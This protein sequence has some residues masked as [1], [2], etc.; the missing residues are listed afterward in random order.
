MCN[1]GRAPTVPMVLVLWCPVGFGACLL[2]LVLLAPDRLADADAGSGL[3]ACAVVDVVRRPR[4]A[5]RQRRRL[6]A[7]VEATAAVFYARD[8]QPPHPLTFCS[9]GIRSLGISPDDLAEASDFW[10]QRLHP[11]DRDAYAAELERLPDSGGV[12]LSYRLQAADGR[13]LWLSDQ[14]RLMEDE[15]GE[16]AEIV[17]VI[18]DITPLVAAQGL[19]RDTRLQAEAVLENIPVG[20]AIVS[21]ERRLLQVNDSF[22]A[23][24][25]R[26]PEELAGHSTRVLYS[27]EE[28]W[29]RFGAL[30]YPAILDSDTFRSELRLSRGDGSEFWAALTGRLIDVRRPQAGLVWVVDDISVRKA[31]EH[32][33]QERQELFEHVFNSNTAV[34]LLIQPGSGLILDANPA[35]AAFYGHALEALRGKPLADLTCLPPDEVVAELESARLQRKRSALLR[36]RTAEGDFRDVE[37]YWGPV[38]VTGQVLVLAIVHDVTDRLSAQREVA[39][40]AEELARSNAE[41]EQFAYVASHDLRQP[42]RM[43]SSYLSLLERRLAERLAPEEHEFLGYARDGAKRMDQLILDLLEYSRIGRDRPREPIPMTEVV[44]EALL[45]LEVAVAEAGAE[46]SLPASLPRVSANRTEMV[47]LLQN[48]M[49]NALK[50]RHAV[51]PPRIRL[52]CARADNHWMFCLADNGIGIDPMAADRIFGIFQRLHGSGE[53]EGTGIGLAVCRKI[54]AQHGGAIWAEP[55]EEGTRFHFTLPVMPTGQELSEVAP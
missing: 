37:V 35:A 54:L 6:E 20:V 40:Q 29:Q 36:Q 49:G 30:A 3:L 8:A 23:L 19:V 5:D 16:G 12:Q 47:R 27:R 55:A 2:V 52:T 38:T 26:R 25:R 18:T 31:A 43:V 17:G 7:M 24:F 11:D 45:N 41:L 48:L 4:A 42:L 9:A 44:A 33:Q 50:Y 15:D 13:W 53:Y 46:L 32:A 51:R 1:T 28:D 22:A 39:R 10:Q 14:I 34:K 21:P